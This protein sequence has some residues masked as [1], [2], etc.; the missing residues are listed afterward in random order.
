MKYFL[1]TFGCQMNKN[2]SERIAGFLNFLG[3]TRSAKAEN[4]DL[5]IVNTCSV[6]QSAEDRVHGL[7]RNWSQ[8]KAKKP[9]LT[10]AV[11]GCMPGRDKDGKLKS[12]LKGVDLYFPIHEMGVLSRW[13]GGADLGDYLELAPA[14]TSRFQ[15]FITIQTGCDNYC[16]YCVVPQ[17][18]GREKNRPAKEIINEVKIAIENGAKEIILLGQVVNN[19][20]DPDLPL[21]N[22]PLKKGEG[23]SF[24]DLL[25]EL[26]KLAGLERLH[27]TAADPRYFSDAQIEA[28][29][30]PKQV[31]YLHLPV[32]SGDNEILRKMNRQYTR[33]QYIDLIKKIRQ[34]K[35]SIAIGTDIIAG[36]CGE[37]EK[38]FQNTVALYKECDFDISYT[39][40][41]SQRSGT[42][43]ARAFKD[44]VP[45]L[46]KK[47]RWQI[48]QE[49]MEETTYRKNQK[50]IGK[51]VSVLADKCEAGICSGNSS[52]MKLA[53]FAGAKNLIGKILDVK[54]TSADVWVLKGEIILPLPNPPLIYEMSE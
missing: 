37:T 44:D 48:L 17:A 51:T 49:L 11:T 38:Q 1:V 35:P 10:I 27:F 5:L 25:K 9:D 28:L 24:V 20:R 3:M 23:D 30:L 41:Y 46:E 43:A 26:N 36:F 50:Y 7:V 33:E 2:D 16:T 52:E 45:R 40:M 31:N 39:A 4:S 53:Q 8:L 47:R 22:L 12:R 42:A 15:T 21:P 29:K 6:R 14:R 34:A 32:Q 13:L 54:I 19:Y 18:R